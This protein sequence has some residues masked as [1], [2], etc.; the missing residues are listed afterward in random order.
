MK[1]QLGRVLDERTPELSGEGVRISK[2]SRS[3]PD[4]IIQ[5]R[6]QS[7]LTPTW[8]AKGRSRGLPGCPLR[9]LFLPH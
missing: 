4:S 1:I 6:M 3:R 7:R 9:P 2:A 5:I 8:A